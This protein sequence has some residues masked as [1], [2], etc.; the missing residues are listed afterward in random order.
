MSYQYNVL[1]AVYEIFNHIYNTKT[2]VK[3]PKVKMFPDYRIS[4]TF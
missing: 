1:F 2:N 3:I 4:Y